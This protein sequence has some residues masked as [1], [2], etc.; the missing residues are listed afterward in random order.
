VFY[1]KIHFL[2]AATRLWLTL[3][4]ARF[5]INLPQT[6]HAGFAALLSGLRR[7]FFRQ[8]EVF[9][10][11]LKGTNFGKRVAKAGLS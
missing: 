1:S 7:D 9:V 4:V 6:T 3:P 10:C 11:G 2:A 5:G 8:G